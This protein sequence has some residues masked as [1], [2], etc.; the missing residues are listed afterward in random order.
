MFKHGHEPFWAITDNVN[1]TL[2]VVE[3][4]FAMATFY[5]YKTYEATVNSWSELLISGAITEK[6]AFRGCRAEILLT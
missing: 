6:L 1:F 2:K 4:A 3:T 5:L